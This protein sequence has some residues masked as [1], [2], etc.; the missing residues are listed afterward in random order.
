MESGGILFDEDVS[1]FTDEV[2]RIAPDVSWITLVAE[3]V[4][5]PEPVSLELPQAK[6]NKLSIIAR[7]TVM[8]SL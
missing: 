5:V 2:S 1:G 3:S 8:H 4:L 7:Q 6:M